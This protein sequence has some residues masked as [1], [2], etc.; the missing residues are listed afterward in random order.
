MARHAGLRDPENRR[1]LADVQAFEAEQPQQPQPG[2]VAQQPE[3]AC[4]MHIYKS[5]LVDEAVQ[6][7]NSG[8]GSPKGTTR[9]RRC[10]AGVELPKL[11]RKRLGAFAETNSTRSHGGTEAHGG[12][13]WKDLKAARQKA[14]GAALR[15]ARTGQALRASPVPSCLR[16]EFLRALRSTPLL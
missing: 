4:A 7:R 12:E 9:R 2:L 10:T 13:L 5:T 11:E 14:R 1:Q 8:L 15:A 3:E 16:A 6:G